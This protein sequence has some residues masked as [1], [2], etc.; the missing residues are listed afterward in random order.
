MQL[1]TQYP[2]KTSI[3]IEGKTYIELSEV[4][5]ILENIGKLGPAFQ[6]VA[7]ASEKI[8]NVF[9]DSRPKVDNLLVELQEAAGTSK[10]S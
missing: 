8:R 7:D 5:E 3:R 6:Q 1:L 2:F 10:E 9:S 4:N